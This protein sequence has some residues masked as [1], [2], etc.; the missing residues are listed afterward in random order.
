MLWRTRRHKEAER[1]F[2]RA[3]ELNPNFALALRVSVCP[4]RPRGV[5]GSR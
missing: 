4:R 3:L 1:A 2:R 5:G